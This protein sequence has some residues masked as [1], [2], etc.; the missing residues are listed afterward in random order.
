MARIDQN[1]RAKGFAPDSPA[2]AQCVLRAEETQTVSASDDDRGVS[3]MPISDAPPQQRPRS[4][5]HSPTPA[6]TARNEALA[7]ASL[8]LNPAHAEFDGCVKDLKDT[9]YAIENPQD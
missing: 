6:E 2:L 3:A 7:C 5:F 4:F 8:G 1:C 9:F